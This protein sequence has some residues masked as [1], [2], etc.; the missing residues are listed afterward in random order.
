MS[1]AESK[2]FAVRLALFY[3]AVF[4]MVG[5]HLPFFPVWLKAI[6]IDPA[7]IG[8]IIAVP[9]ITRFTTLPF[10][11]AVAEHRQALRAA[12]IFT[13]FATTIGFA[14]L[15][16]LREPVAVLIVYVLTACCGRRRCR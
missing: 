11:T 3:G 10:I 13:A 5:T 4:G 12:M 8:V 7:W 14:V 9:S 2:R 16:L 6:G 15:G 1:A